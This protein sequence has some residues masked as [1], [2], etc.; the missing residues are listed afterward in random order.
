MSQFA[1]AGRHSK[2]IVRLAAFD[3][4]YYQEEM[5]KKLAGLHQHLSAL[6]PR[7]TYKMTTLPG[8]D[9]RIDPETK[10]IQCYCNII[11]STPM[12]PRYTMQYAYIEAQHA[13]HQL[14]VLQTS[15]IL[16]WSLLFLVHTGPNSPIRT[17]AYL[18]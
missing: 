3:Q 4:K 16:L 8:S 15:C 17:Q 13:F 2:E 12:H 11:L 9:K 14:P 18:P 7:V 10:K 1:L 5:V 6:C